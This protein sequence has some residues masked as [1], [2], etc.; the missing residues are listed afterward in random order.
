MRVG[1]VEWDLEKKTNK[2]DAART[3]GEP[4]RIKPVLA[5]RNDLTILE[6]ERD[7]PRILAGSQKLMRGYASKL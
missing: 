4:A 6:P 2:L 5:L 7:H 3:D 1:C